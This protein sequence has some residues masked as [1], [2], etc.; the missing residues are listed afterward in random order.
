MLSKTDNFYL[1]IVLQ[2]KIPL[3]S[4]SILF[5][6]YQ[7]DTEYF[8][9]V[10][11]RKTVSENAEPIKVP[12]CGLMCPLHKSY[13]LHKDILPEADLRYPLP[14]KVQIRLLFHFHKK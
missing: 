1:Y 7:R 14:F 4:S 2:L 3:F 12:N 9:Q 11:Y 5:E 8:V 13:D 6:L 10:T